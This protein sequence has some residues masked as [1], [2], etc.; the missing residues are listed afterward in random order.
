MINEFKND[1]NY[2]IVFD[3]DDKNEVSDIIAIKYYDDYS[4]L[5]VDL[6]HC[7]F[8]SKDKAGARLK[9]LYEVCGQAQRSFHWKHNMRN[10]IEH[11]K[12]REAH[13]FKNSK[14]SRFEKGGNEELQT[15]INMVESGMSKIVFN[16]IIV[17]PGVSKKLISNEQLS[18][19]G[20][21]DMLLKNTGNNFE[22]IIDD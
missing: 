4:K 18:L 19:L 11:I 17:Q 15:I 16:V 2:Q 5:V 7:K 9:D 1:S 10:L 22:V 8:S 12:K 21:T 3:D 14:P 20:A 13:R 6:Y